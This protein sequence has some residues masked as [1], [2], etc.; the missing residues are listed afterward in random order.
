MKCYIKKAL[1]EMNLSLI[2]SLNRMHNGLF[3]Y[4][5]PKIFSGVVIISVVHLSNQ[6]TTKIGYSNK[7]SEYT[8]NEFVINKMNRK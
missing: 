2:Q 1:I 3:L 7:S 8:K 4:M 6:A 5:M